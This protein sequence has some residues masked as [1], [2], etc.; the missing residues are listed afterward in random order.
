MIIVDGGC[1]ILRGY[2]VAAF[3]AA[4]A[5]DLHRPGLFAPAHLDRPAVHKH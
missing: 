5:A 1:D 4:A 2:V 3:G